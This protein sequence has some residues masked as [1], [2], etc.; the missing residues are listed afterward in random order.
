MFD[1]K[2]LEIGY[3][4]S[5]IRDLYVAGATIKID[6]NIDRNIY[7][8]GDKVTIKGE[9]GGNVNI[10]ADTIIIEEGTTISGTLTYPDTATIN[11]AEEATIEKTKVYEVKKIE[12]TVSWKTIIREK[13]IGYLSLLVIAFLLISL[14]SKLLKTIKGE[15]KEIGYAFKLAGIGFLV[16]IATPVVAL[17]AIISLIG[18]PLGIIIAMLYGILIY[19]S[20][21]PTSIYIGNWV[22]NKNMKNDYLV[23]AVSLLIIYMIRIIPIIGGIIGFLSLILGLGIYASVFHKFYKEGKK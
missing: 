8:G 18:L 19:I 21:I 13:I 11:I 15:K 3:S 17:F 4:Q 16:L 22:V 23:L 6:S 12:T 1:K 20:M 9:I 14:H 5:T 10:S 2:M 7:A